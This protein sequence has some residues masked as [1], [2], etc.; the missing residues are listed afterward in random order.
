MSD[1][2]I[3]PYEA[4]Q[5]R[6]RVAA[7]LYGLDDALFKVF[8]ATNRSMIVSLPVLMD[9]GRWE[10]FTGYRVQ[11]S[12]ARGPA[13]GG[14]RYD[15]N[16]TLDEVRALAAWMTWKC[17]VVDVPFGGGKGG[18]VCDPTRLSAGEKERLT[19][20]YI[21]EIMDILGPDRDV[22]ANDMGTDAQT[23]A[24]VMDT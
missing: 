3:N 21:A 12:T 22:P 8:M 17:A 4:M 23:M 18:V 20:R 6:L 13:K 5:A 1:T 9:D 24:W 11:H 10:V 2:L 14:I 15:L 16:V 19:R 7:Q